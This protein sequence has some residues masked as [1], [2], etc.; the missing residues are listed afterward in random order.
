M[1]ELASLVIPD[2][3][4]NLTFFGNSLYHYGLALT[5][6]LGMVVV[7]KIIQLTISS[8][9]EQLAQKTHSGIDEVILEVV[10]SLRL[11]VV[12]YIGLYFGTMVLTS[13]ELWHNALFVGLIV[14]VIHQLIATSYIV[15]E[16]LV[17]QRLGDDNSGN[18]QI[19]VYSIGLVIQISLWAVGLIFIL[20]NF[21]IDVTSLIAAMGV[22]GIAV[23]FALQ[24]V[25]SDLFGSFAIYFDKPFV[26]GDFILVGDKMGTVE[27]IG[28][29]TTRIKSLQGEELVFSNQQLTSATIQNYQRMNERR[30]VFEIGVVF[31]TSVKK[32]HQAVDIV[33]KAIEDQEK[34]R[35]DRAHFK[36]ITDSALSIEAVYYCETPD[37]NDYMDANQSI[38]FTIKE[39]FEKANIKLA[40]PARNI[41]MVTPA[42]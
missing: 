11:Y 18:A 20:S 39:Q 26:P 40:Y 34:V 6:I 28:V 36:A 38:M 42:V 35:I 37:Y 2:S 7:Y 41:H 16:Y 27:K 9:L 21:G 24:Q 30:I 4:L 31:D 10:K 13:S 19:A 33:K 3:I 15:I 17:R 25:L 12:A 1:Q 8:H 29:K 22:G 23:A 5:I 14:L 32:L